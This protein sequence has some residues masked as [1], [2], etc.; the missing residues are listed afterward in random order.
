MM[1]A[2]SQYK[3]QYD[4]GIL[5]LV[6]FMSKLAFH[7]F[8]GVEDAIEFYFVEEGYFTDVAEGLSF[9]SDNY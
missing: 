7:H 9:Y 1:K 6:E 3:E 2:I 4:M 5:D 8:D